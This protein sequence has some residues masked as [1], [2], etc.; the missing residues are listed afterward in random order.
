LN[1][2]V[3]NI[4]AAQR[5]SLWEKVALILTSGRLH[6]IAI[7]SV[8]IASRAIPPIPLTIMRLAVASLILCG[9][10]IVLRPPMRWQ[11]R[12]VCDLFIS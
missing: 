9:I 7:A 8:G 10:L 11:R 6:A 2:S 5:R 4:T 12:T 3:P 1:A